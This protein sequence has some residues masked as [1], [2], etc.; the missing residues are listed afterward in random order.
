MPGGQHQPLAAFH[1]SNGMRLFRHLEGLCEATAKKTRGR[2]QCVPWISAE[3]HLNDN[4]AQTLA[5][6]SQ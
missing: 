6:H 5:V 1:S 3:A 2:P 4:C